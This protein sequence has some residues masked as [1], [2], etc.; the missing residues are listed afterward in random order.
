MQRS[1]QSGLKGRHTP[2]RLR[3]LMFKG[4]TKSPICDSSNVKEHFIRDW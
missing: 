4:F 1:A 2:L 3:P